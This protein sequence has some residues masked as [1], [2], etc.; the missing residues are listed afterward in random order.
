MYTRQTTFEIGRKTSSLLSLTAQTEKIKNSTQQKKDANSSLAHSTWNLFTLLNNNTLAHFRSSSSSSSSSSS[1]RRH[2]PP[3]KIQLHGNH[4]NAKKVK[5]G[6]TTA[7]DP[8][9]ANTQ[10]HSSYAMLLGNED[11]PKGVNSDS[12][13]AL[14]HTR[15]AAARHK[16]FPQKNSSS[17]SL[18]TQNAT[19]YSSSTMPTSI[20]HPSH[21]NRSNNNNNNNS[22]SNYTKASSTTSIRMIIASS[23]SSF[24][25]ELN[26]F[27][28]TKQINRN[29]MKV[30]DEKDNSPLL[31]ASS[32]TQQINVRDINYRPE[33]GLRI[34][35]MLGSM[36]LMII[37]YL[38]WRNRCHCLLHRF[39]LSVSCCSCFCF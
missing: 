19:S 23:T 30:I 5:K 27:P 14:R 12:F 35:L 16:R 8:Y 18:F 9:T 3:S 4:K 2:R 36:L 11:A 34:A 20:S 21:H 26:F 15:A 28:K 29:D 13:A 1:K 39:G 24:F 6:I 37:F 22:N 7:S 17:S 32:S 31:L 33:V 38:L 10:A 25:T